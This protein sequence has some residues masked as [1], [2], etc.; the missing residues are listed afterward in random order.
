[1]KGKITAEFSHVISISSSKSAIFDNFASLYIAF[2]KCLKMAIFHTFENLVI[3]PPIKG[4][5]N[6]FFHAINLI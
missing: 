4:F 5:L 1:M 3:L 2:A 6:F